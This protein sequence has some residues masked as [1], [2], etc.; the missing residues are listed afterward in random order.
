MVG[1]GRCRLL[2]LNLTTVLVVFL[3]GLW[4]LLGCDNRFQLLSLLSRLLRSNFLGFLGFFLIFCL[5]G[6][7][8]AFGALPGYFWGWGKVHKFLD[9]IYIN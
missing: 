1:R 9:C 7:F 5:F 4:L 6:S 2:S 8:S 3:L